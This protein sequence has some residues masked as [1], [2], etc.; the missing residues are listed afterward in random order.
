MNYTQEQYQKAD[1]TPIV[2][3]LEKIGY[4]L[5]SVGNGRMRVNEMDSME[6][7]VTKNCFYRHSAQEGGGA[8][9]L[10]SMLIGK[11]ITEV[12]QELCGDSISFV[13]VAQEKKS[14]NIKKLK[15]NLSYYQCVRHITDMLLLI[16]RRN[17]KYFQRL[18]AK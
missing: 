13:S 18:L 8:V 5:K 9:Q 7:S 11:S 1:Q 3:I 2:E 14:E 12:V 15:N 6:I 4:S 16:C 10:L 17:E